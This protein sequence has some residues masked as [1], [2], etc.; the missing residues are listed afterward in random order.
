MASQREERGRSVAP[1]PSTSP[2]PA[3]M[4]CVSACLSATLLD[5]SK[6]RWMFAL[7]PRCRLAFARL[8][9]ARLGR[10][11]PR[12]GWRARGVARSRVGPSESVAPAAP[13]DPERR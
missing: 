10:R 12:Q 2:T 5:K 13:S 4:S 1:A 9:A 11:R 7:Y 8:R 6:L 3:I